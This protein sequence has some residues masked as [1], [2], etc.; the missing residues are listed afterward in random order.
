MNALATT[1]SIITT[2]VRPIV[3]GTFIKYNG[4]GAENGWRAG[5]YAGAILFAIS[6][7][8]VSFLYH[9][10]PPVQPRQ[11]LRIIASVAC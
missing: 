2:S 3:Q 11:S 5:S 4:G 10:G 7:V 6:F 1:I 8:M 9:P